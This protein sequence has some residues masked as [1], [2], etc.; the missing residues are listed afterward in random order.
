MTKLREKNREELT[1]GIEESKKR[2]RQ[3]E[4]RE[5]VL[6]QLLKVTQYHGLQCGHKRPVLFSALWRTW[7]WCPI[8]VQL[9][10]AM[11]T[12]AFTML[13]LSETLLSMAL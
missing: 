2:I 8:L 10:C 9:S 13:A 11:R 4:N 3:F 5:K 6:R 12:T 7:S 1:A